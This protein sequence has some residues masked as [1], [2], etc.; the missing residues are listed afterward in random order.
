MQNQNPATDQTLR[1]AT[2]HGSPL[3]AASARTGLV[4][5][6][7][8]RFLFQVA[9]KAF[10]D[11]AVLEEERGQ[12]FDRC[13]LYIGHGSEIPQNC[14]FLTRSV[15]G[16]ELVFNRDRGGDKGGGDRDRDRGRGG[17]QGGRF[18]N[19]DYRDSARQPREPRW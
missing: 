14:D 3:P 12:I 5:E 19:E 11:E 7:R 6:D 10:V 16:R 1:P 18:S 13:W 2:L 8:E 9:R 15:G 17:K 4:M